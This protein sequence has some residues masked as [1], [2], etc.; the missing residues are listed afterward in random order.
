[1]AKIENSNFQGL[2]PFVAKCKSAFKG[3][4]KARRCFNYYMRHTND[5][6]YS[7]KKVYAYIDD[8]Y[9]KLE[10][11]KKISCKKTTKQLTYLTHRYERLNYKSKISFSIITSVFISVF[12]TLMFSL[13]QTPDANGTTY[14]TLIRDI[15]K[16]DYSLAIQSPGSFFILLVFQFLTFIFWFSIFAIFAWLAVL[17]TKELSLLNS[18]VNL[19]VFPYERET[20]IK[21]ISTYNSDLGALLKQ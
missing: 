18:K 8:F 16:I 2:P 17:L 9:S 21:T 4:C 7:T 6:H 20:I 10:Y 15:D 11:N 5:L 19:I 13:L 1:M 14:F 12:I 3:D